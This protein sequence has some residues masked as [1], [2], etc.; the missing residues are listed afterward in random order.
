MPDRPR[1][2]DPPTSP[3]RRGRS[4]KMNESVKFADDVIPAE[5]SNDGSGDAPQIMQLPEEAPQEAAARSGAIAEPSFAF[6][7]PEAENSNASVMSWKVSEPL[8]IEGRRVSG[9]AV[10]M[11]AHNVQKQL[12]VACVNVSICFLS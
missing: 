11:S 10:L 2:P 3:S 7:Q 4:F 12:T 8:V 9:M 6:D 5:S 1:S